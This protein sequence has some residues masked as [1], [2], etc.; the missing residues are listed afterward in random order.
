VLFRSRGLEG[1]AGEFDLENGEGFNQDRKEIKTLSPD[2]LY[3]VQPGGL[4]E[5]DSL[6]S[7]FLASFLARAAFCNLQINSIRRPIPAAGGFRHLSPNGENLARAARHL[8]DNHKEIF[9]QIIAKL[10]KKIPG[11]DKVEAKKTEEGTVILKFKNQNF[12]DPF[13]AENMSD[14]TLKMFAYLVLLN[15]PDP[16]PLLCI[17]EPENFLYVDL[18]PE[19][20]EEIRS[21]G[22]GKN[23]VFVS[24]HSPDF[25]DGADSQ[26]V[27]YISRD[28]NGFSQIKCANDDKLIHN[29]A[30]ENKMGYLWRNHYIKN[31]KIS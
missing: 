4:A 13:L 31:L 23:Q 22:G 26:E 25:L 29:L 10:P 11:L 12:K 16:H 5:L 30:K 21:Y 15:D 20:C 2:R 19:L 6:F 24:T 27:F 9:N 7:F 18:L 3:L 28:E 17:E 14:G 8:F 1:P